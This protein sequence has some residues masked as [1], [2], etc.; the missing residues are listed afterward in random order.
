MQIVINDHRK[1][2]AI[3][4]EFNQAFPN[5]KLE[6]FKKPSKIGGT[7]SEKE[8]LKDGNTVGQGRV[9]HNKGVATINSGMTVAEVEQNLADVYGL[10]VKIFQ[11]KN[12]SWK[13]ALPSAVI[14]E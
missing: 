1:L 11:R 13:E 12:A 4:E 6:F 10:S 8:L 7:P 14:N 3:K 9:V 2:H 5:F